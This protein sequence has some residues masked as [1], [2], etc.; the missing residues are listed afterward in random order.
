MKRNGDRIYMTSYH[1]RMIF[2]DLT[3]DYFDEFN[4]DMYNGKGLARRIVERLQD[5]E[6]K[7][8]MLQCSIML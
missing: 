8:A 3:S 5:E 6:I 2:S 1:G 7:K 4:Y